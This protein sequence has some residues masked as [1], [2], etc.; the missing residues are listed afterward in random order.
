MLLHKTK[1][2]DQQAAQKNSP[3][4]STISRAFCARMIII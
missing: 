3:Y 1:Q 2:F 4:L